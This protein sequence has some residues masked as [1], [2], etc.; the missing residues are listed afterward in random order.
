[1]FDTVR[2]LDDHAQ[3]TELRKAFVKQ[4][5]PDVK[6]PT[7][8]KVREREGGEMLQASAKLTKYFVPPANSAAA[9]G[10]GKSEDTALFVTLPLG[11]SSSGSGQSS[12]AKRKASAISILSGGELQPTP[13]MVELIENGMF[14]DAWQQLLDM[15]IEFF[16]DGENVELQERVCS[17]VKVME[18]WKGGKVGLERTL[19]DQAKEIEDNINNRADNRLGRIVGIRL[20]S[21]CGKSHLL[22]ETPKILNAHGIYITYNLDQDLQHD[23]NEPKGAILLR[24]LLRIATVPNKK[25]PD[26][27]RSNEGK[28]LLSL[29]TDTLRSFAVHRLGKLEKEIFIGVDEVMELKNVARIGSIMSE[30]GTLAAECYH[31]NNHRQCNVFVSSLHREPFVTASKRDIIRWSPEIPDETAVELILQHY[32]EGRDM[33]RCKAIVLS[34]AGFH[35]RSIVFA[36]QAIGSFMNPSVQAVLQQVYDRWKKKV[37]QD[38]LNGVKSYVIEACKGNT[39]AGQFKPIRDQVEDYLDRMCALPP[40]LIC[41]AF[42]VVDDNCTVD[43]ENPL[44]GVFNCDYAYTDPAKHL[45]QFGLNFDFF[46]CSQNLPVIPDQAEVIVPSDSSSKLPQWYKQ[47]KFPAQMEKSDESLLSL[48]NHQPILSEV[49]EAPSTQKYYA[50]KIVNHPL[51]D[52]AFVA[53]HENGEKCFVL[54]QDKLNK[55]VPKAVKDLNL[56]A[57]LIKGKHAEKFQILCIVNVIGATSNSTSQSKLQYPYVTVR[58]SEVDAFYSVNFAPVARFA[59]RRHELSSC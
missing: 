1:M 55:D 9:P 40:P 59:R 38:V 18:T 10:P 8:V 33:K 37:D 7:T 58:E 30:L 43:L 47:L 36:A 17:P 11:P 27:F 2:E 16:G 51:I 14:D 35:F 44:F 13:S 12:P 6:R 56:A 54:I 52:R 46:R 29:K 15:S 22:L 31:K 57:G 24:I 25:C 49:G 21:G 4:L 42:G 39:F 53:H 32:T 34:C 26:F 45:E 41:G 50:S 19:R 20:G 28:S 23:E 3:I 5:E 48:K